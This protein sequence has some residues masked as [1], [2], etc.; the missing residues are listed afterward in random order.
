MNKG[1]SYK[2]AM[3]KQGKAGGKTSPGS[4]KEKSS[5]SFRA[6]PGEKKTRREQQTQ[7]Q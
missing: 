1:S 5:I 7:D 2:N 6:L 3:K 4:G